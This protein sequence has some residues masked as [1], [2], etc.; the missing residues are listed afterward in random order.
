MHRLILE[1][2]CY[3]AAENPRI[4]G[5]DL[6]V[7]YFT[8]ENENDV[9]KIGIFKTEKK[10]TFL[11]FFRQ[12]TGSEIEINKGFSLS[13]IDKAALIYNKDKESGYVL[14][15]VDNNKNGDM[16]TGLRTFKG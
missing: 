6:F 7:V 13:K 14:Q 4:Q 12:R 16:Y 5:G 9:D 11:Q 3:E 2:Y 10:E 15:V 1:D 8:A